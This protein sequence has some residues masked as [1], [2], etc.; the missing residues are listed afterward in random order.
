VAYEIEFTTALRC[1][2]TTAVITYNLTTI[3][4][5]L[6]VAFQLATINRH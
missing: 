2:V 4:N 3:S 1:D 5:Q 6:I